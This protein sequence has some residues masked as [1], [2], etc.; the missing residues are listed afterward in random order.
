[1][2]HMN[3]NLKINEKGNA[4]IGGADTT[5]LAEEYGTPLYVIDEGRVRENYNRVY[6]A[7]TK[8]VQIIKHVTLFLSLH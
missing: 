3:L 4:E 6:N 7:F 2:I 5:E 1:M 8:Y